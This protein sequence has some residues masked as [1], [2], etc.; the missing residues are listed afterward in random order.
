M[1]LLRIAAAVGDPSGDLDLQAP[2]DR[3]W[4]EKTQQLPPLLAGF[5][6]AHE[7]LQERS[8]KCGG[9][10]EQQYVAMCLLDFVV[11]FLDVAAALPRASWR[12]CVRNVES[13]EE[14]GKLLCFLANHDHRG[15]ED[16][17][18][19]MDR[20]RPLRSAEGAFSTILAERRYTWSHC[21]RDDSCTRF[22]RT[23][24]DQR[25]FFF[26]RVGAFS[27][28]RGRHLSSAPPARGTLRPAIEELAAKTWTHPRSGRDVQFAITT[29][30]RWYYLARNDKLDPLGVLRRAVRKDCGKVSSRRRGRAVGLSV[31]RTP[32]LELQAALRQPGGAGEGKR[33][34]RIVTLVFHGPPLP[35]GS[36]PGAQ[37]AS[38]QGP[39]RRS[40]CRRAT[41]DARRPQLRSRVCR[42]PLAPRFP[43]RFPESTHVARR[44]A[45][46]LGAGHSRRPLATLLPPAMV[47]LG[48]GRGSGA[49]TVPGHSEARLAPR[50]D[51]R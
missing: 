42:L 20:Q 1:H 32:A 17:D 14:W 37:A 27:L 48:D 2:G 49:W 38:A 26:G 39:P 40:P 50:A 5:D 51:D 31:W 24:D 4:R 10:V 29:I 33:V 46:A 28:L 34:A 22:V 11:L 6:V 21:P 23:C 16:Q 47:S 18:L 30:E 25:R 8:W 19:L 13:C 44:V 35:A 3:D 36:R 43:P 7:D 9:H 15:P 12:S 45:A 41:P